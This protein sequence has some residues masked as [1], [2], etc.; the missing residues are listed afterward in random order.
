MDRRAKELSAAG[1]R[2][3]SFAAG[4]PDFPTPPEIVEAAIEAC[5]DPRMHH[6][7]PTAGLPELREA[8]A[9]KTSRESGTEISAANVLVTSGTKQ[10][11][12][13]GF[14]TLLDPG[15][16]VL[17]ASPYWVTFPEAIGL[18]GGVSVVVPADERRGFRVSVEQL[19]EHLTSRTKAL[20]FVSPSN[21]TGAVY[22]EALMAEIGSWAAE[23]GL[24]VL[25]DEIYEKFTYGEARFH[26]MPAVTPALAQR[27]LRFNGTSK[28]YAMTGWR[29][30][31]LIGPE[32]VVAAATNLQ[33][34]VCGNINNVGQRAALAALRS[35]TASVERMRQ[36]FSKRRETIL[37]GLGQ[38]PGIECPP[39]DGA[40]Y[41]F[42]SVEGLLGRTIAG[43]TVESSEQL[44]AVFLD[45]ARVA[46][47]PGEAFGCSGHL[48]LSYA[49][50]DELL[51]EGISRLQ[52]LLS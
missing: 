13:H 8:I 41:V 4:E 31:W 5:R 50:A 14:A 37:E 36:T 9:E 12:A 34:H 46:V 43:H 6:Y 11:V 22:P 28:S 7:T 16:E 21:P 17:V 40:F 18:A 39:P 51:E 42:P 48:R 3:I 38:L 45:E 30:G 10:A 49:L 24:W 25:S 26:S 44:A 2:V 1:E 35:G 19:E 29:V 15:D 47:V 20:L 23:H 32:P 27:T 33:S 52:Q